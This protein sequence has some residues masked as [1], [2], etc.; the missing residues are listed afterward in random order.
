MKTIKFLCSVAILSIVFTSCKKDEA[1]TPNPDGSFPECIVLTGDQTTALTLTDHVTDPNVPDYC[2]A[3]TFFIKAEVVVNPGVLIQ[4][5][6]GSKIHVQANGSFKSVGTANSKITIR[7]ED[8]LVTGQ[9]ASIHYSTNNTENQ[10]I[11]TNVSGGG[12]G[13]TYDGMVYI[14]YQG[15][16]LIDNCNILLSSSNG[17]KT[18]NY[19]SQLGGISNCDITACA[20]YPM[21]I[22]SRLIH[23]IE[24]N[25]TGAGNGNEMILVGTS[26]LQTPMTWNKSNFAYKINGS[27]SIATDVTVQPGTRFR[28]PAG[29]KIEIGTN[30]SFNC[31]GTA[32]EKIRFFGPT[33]TPGSW[34]CINFYA[35]NSTL[36]RFEYCDFDYGGGNGTYIGMLT[37]WTNATVRV[38]NSSF[39]NSARWGI[40]Y[41]DFNCT[42]VNDGNNTFSGNALG[43]IGF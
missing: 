1:P 35:T 22:N 34:E 28:M 19:N 33:T 9:W 36:N 38:G 24:S 10:L 23:E 8:G 16:A 39:T 5:N 12:N 27:L 4:M 42:L 13:T 26:Q 3:N 14:G 21:E 7:G 20:L 18:E 31:V 15:Y 17:I 11:H 32:T 41:N 43:D 37:L 2:V 29:S 40:H 30:G 25:N 6:D